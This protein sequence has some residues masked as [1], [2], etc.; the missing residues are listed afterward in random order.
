[1]AKDFLASAEEKN[2]TNGNT[3]RKTTDTPRREHE[4]QTPC[5]N[6]DADPSAV[7]LLAD[8]IGSLRELLRARESEIDNLRKQLSERSEEFAQER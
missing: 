6:E 4:T 2:S 8:Q 1:L 3:S 5:R 7:G